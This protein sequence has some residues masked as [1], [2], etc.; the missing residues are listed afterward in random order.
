MFND[1]QAVC[2]AVGL[3]IVTAGAPAVAQYAPPAY[4]RYVREQQIPPAG[5]NWA[6]DDDDDDDVGAAFAATGPIDG[7]T[8]ALFPA[9]AIA[10]FRSPL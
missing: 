3:A 6:D 4:E 2:A 7:A 1:F 9:T 5:G 8:A 10:V